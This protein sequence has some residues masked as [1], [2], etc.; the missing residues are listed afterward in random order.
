MAITFA[1]SSCKKDKK[2]LPPVDENELI[3]TIKVKFTNATNP[4]DVKTFTWKDLDGQGGADPVVDEIKLAT[5]KTYKMEVTAVLNETTNPAQDITE[6]IK[7]ED[8]EHLFVYKPS[9]NLLTVQITDKDKN[10]YYVGLMADVNTNTAKNG[11]LQIILRHQLGVKDGTEAPGS[12]DFDITY[13]VKI[14]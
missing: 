8:Y 11:T 5:N 10:N 14:Q 3:T 6:E 1:V 9:T 12:T 7:E 4:T 13:P 2:E